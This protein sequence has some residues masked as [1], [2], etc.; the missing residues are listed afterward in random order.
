MDFVYTAGA[1]GHG[2]WFRQC[3]RLAYTPRSASNAR[4]GCANVL[5]SRA[6]RTYTRSE[7]VQPV[8]TV[9]THVDAATSAERSWSGACAVVHFSAPAPTTVQRIASLPRGAAFMQRAGKVTRRLT[10]TCVE[11]NTRNARAFRKS[12]ADSRP[13]TG[14]IVNPSPNPTRTN[15][16]RYKGERGMGGGGVCTAG[17]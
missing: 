17:R 9:H 4:E 15:H 1:H 7:A 5:A 12:R 16:R 2:E 8:Y 11:K 14:R 13:P 10:H 6:N 3:A